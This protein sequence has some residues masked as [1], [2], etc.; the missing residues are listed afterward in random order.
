MSWGCSPSGPRSEGSDERKPKSIAIEA[1]LD[2]HRSVPAVPDP[3]WSNI[4]SGLSPS[5]QPVPMSFDILE[6]L[7]REWGELLTE[8]IPSGIA[9]LLAT[10]RSLF[11]NSWFNYEFMAVGVTISLQA[12]E[13]TFRQVVYPDASNRSFRTLRNRAAKE[14]W[15]ATDLADRLDAGIELRNSLSHPPD[16]AAFTVGM[17]A[18]MI[19]NSHHIV[20]F[21]CGYDFVG[22]R[23]EVLR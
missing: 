5:G 4:L 1:G 6:G 20:N 23:A 22:R 19:V 16:Q 18:P 8:P 7:S 9:N 17:A 2:H 13:A 10:A 3:R 11:A 21:L 14:G 15:L 12:V